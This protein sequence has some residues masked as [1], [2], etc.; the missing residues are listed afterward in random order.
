MSRLLRTAPTGRLLATLAAAATGA[1]ALR[2]DAARV[3]WIELDGA[4]AVKPDAFAWLMG[5]EAPATLLDVVDTFDE[6][7]WRT[8]ID[9]VV[10]RLRQPELSL[11]QVEEIG[12]AIR[13][14]R[15]AGK[16][17]HVFAD[18]YGPAELM[19]AA[20]A[21]DVLLQTGGAVTF[22]GLHMEEMFLADTLGLAGLRADFVQI[23]EYKG[24]SEQLGRAAPSEAWDQNI[25]GLLDG[26]YEN[27]RGIVRAGRGLSEAQ[28]DEA[29]REAW[30][31]DG[32]RAVELGLIDAVIDRLDLEARLDEEHGQVEYEMDMGPGA[33][34]AI[35]LGNP[36]KM[37]EVLMSEPDNS[38]TGPAVAIVHIDG[39]IIDGESTPAGLLGGA[40]VGSATIREALA[41]I[42]EEALIKGVIIRVNSPGGSA[43]ASESIWLG[44]R[45][46]AEKKP[47]W[48]SVGSM[49]ASGGYYIAVSGDKVYANPSSIVGSIGVVGGKIVMEGLYEKL[50]VGVTTRARGPAAAMF[51]S[52]AP[53]DEAQRSLIRGR[54]E[55]TYDLFVKR[56][57]AG[58]KG[59][60]I[61]QTAEGR[62]FTGE[63]AKSLKMVDEIGGIEVALGDMA[64]ELGLTTGGFEVIEYPGPRSLQDM[65]GQMLGMA[66]VRAGGGAAPGGSLADVMAGV[67]AA[68]GPRAWPQVRDAI[69][70]LLMLRREAVLLMSPRAI[71]VR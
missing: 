69:E 57:R 70:G 47:V 42:E 61:A 54:M 12:A 37:L 32:P 63:R 68:L 71:V 45:R 65:L 20:S 33:A 55:D 58:R 30:L 60:D 14:C 43:I 38:P 62:L 56:V 17:V 34:G 31:L 19:L 49:A 11:P 39:P 48:I 50:R 8:D 46:V 26:L 13:A 28:M 67:E 10:V 21:D 64:D 4:L 52:T 29:M 1:L 53:W 40:Q 23:G 66:G 25:S 44:V 36:F 35:D 51:A 3:G 5:P 15:A 41:E 18:I 16:P 6:A 2:A 59:I 7:A 9:A 27:M 22:P 24:A